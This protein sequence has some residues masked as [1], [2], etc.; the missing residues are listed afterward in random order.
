MGT[1]AEGLP[2]SPVSMLR[3][4]VKWSPHFGRDGGVFILPKNIFRIAFNIEAGGIIKT[5]VLFAI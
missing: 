1:L 4:V 5:Y 2:P 3:Y